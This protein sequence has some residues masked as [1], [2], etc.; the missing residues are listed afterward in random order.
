MKKGT[1]LT[2]VCIILILLPILIASGES[3]LLF[4]HKL[5]GYLPSENGI[6]L[7]YDLFI[8]NTN[9][10]SIYNVKL[11][12]ASLFITAYEN[13]TLTIGDLL[14]HEI[15]EIN[16]QL[17]TPMILTEDKF[18]QQSL[19]WIVEYQDESDLPHEVSL[20]S[21]PRLS[22]DELGGVQ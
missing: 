6:T 14:G 5:T 12:N 1:V 10:F 18:S 3:P 8:E 7:D 13:V 15:R 16:F 19:S 4:Q 20:E 21:H 11:S 17:N 2:F 9:D 22:L